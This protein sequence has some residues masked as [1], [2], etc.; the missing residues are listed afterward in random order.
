MD[1]RFFAGQRV[2]A[3]IADGSEKFKKTKT[4]E[5]TEDDEAARLESFGKFLEEEA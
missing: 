5:V 3:Y 4:T 1:G 2:K